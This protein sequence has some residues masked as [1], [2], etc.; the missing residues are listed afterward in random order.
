MSEVMAYDG[1]ANVAALAQ[2]FSFERLSFF[3]GSFLLQHY[4]LALR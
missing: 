2:L 1:I 3:A 4:V